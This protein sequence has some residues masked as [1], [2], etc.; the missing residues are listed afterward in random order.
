M[1][2]PVRELPDEPGVDRAE[3]KF[4]TLGLFLRAG[5]VV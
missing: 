3:Q 4:S 2:L 5:D 1:Y